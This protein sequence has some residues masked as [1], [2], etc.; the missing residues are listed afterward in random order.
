MYGYAIKIYNMI[1]I[2]VW[3]AVVSIIIIMST[4]AMIRAI[5]KNI[6]NEFK[7]SINFHKEGFKRTNFPIIKI[8]IRGKYRYFLVD[9]GA[10]INVI[11]YECYKEL[12]GDGAVVFK[13]DCGISG[14]GTQS[15]ETD[16]PI[17][18]DTFQVN[19]DKFTEEFSLM[20][21]WAFAREQVSSASG[22]NIIGI[23]GSDFFT[24]AKW[25]L[26]FEDLIIW[27]KK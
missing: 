2:Y 20:K 13:G 16:T 1:G 27:V 3:L 8:K 23:L 5:S 24:R 22:L 6:N 9:S 25:M 14:V 4:W 19:S 21:D 26:D 12:V 7:Y 11:D 10:N 15:K 17:I 18:E